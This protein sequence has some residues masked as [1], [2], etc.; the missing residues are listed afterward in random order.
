MT[1][2]LREFTE[3]DWWGLCGCI[4]PSPDQEPLISHDLEITD[5]PEK[6]QFLK[7]GYDE[8]Q[9]ELVVDAQGIFIAGL[10]KYA[11]QTFEFP[12][13]KIVAKALLNSSPITVSHLEELGFEFINFSK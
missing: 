6:E 10:D 12:I 3:Q 13:G 11:S 7:D 4:K 1:K 8:C 2:L 9:V 5:W